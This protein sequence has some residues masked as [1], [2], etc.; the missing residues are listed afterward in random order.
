MDRERSQK[1]YQLISVV[2]KG[3]KMETLSRL[4]DRLVREH[5]AA[6]FE[7]GLHKP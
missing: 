5:A 1:L 4:T 3:E 6:Q 7:V 2:S